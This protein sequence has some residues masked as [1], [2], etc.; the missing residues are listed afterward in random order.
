MS[1]TRYSVVT[2]SFLNRTA[3]TTK[4]IITSLVSVA[5]LI[6]EMKKERDTRIKEQLNDAYST[7][8]GFGVTDGMTGELD[9]MEVRYIHAEY[10][11]N[12]GI[13]V[14]SNSGCIWVARFLHRS[15]S[16]VNFTTRL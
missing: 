1:S 5:V 16:H 15:C 4:P 10:I 9:E 7:T 3:S 8:K 13:N 14:C 6:P 11:V 2:I 12:D